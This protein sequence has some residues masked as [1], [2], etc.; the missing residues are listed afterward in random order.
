[1]SPRCDPP[2]GWRIDVRP[3][4]PEDEA[5]WRAFMKSM[6]WATRY[7]R[8]ARR[9]E[10]LT[11]ADV[12]RAVRPLPGKEIAYVAVAARDEESRVAGVSRGTYRS[13]GE[14]EFTLVVN[15][16]WQG[17]GIGTRL[18]AA[19][20]DEATHSGHPRIVGRVL[21]TNGNML[22]FVGSLGFAIEDEPQDAKVKRV[23]RR[24]GGPGGAG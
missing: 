19:L 14:C 13:G 18:M 6:S 4:R 9:L 11:E 16:D 10:D 20:M 3:I 17:L 12:R 21:A 7:K 24:V 23:V 22:A 8:G 15:D 5:M 1:M 2:P